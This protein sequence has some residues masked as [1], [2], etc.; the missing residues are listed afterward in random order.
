VPILSLLILPVTIG[1]PPEAV[2]RLDRR[3]SSRKEP[4]AGDRKSRL[5]ANSGN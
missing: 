1:I 4:F 3:R 5:R 2:G